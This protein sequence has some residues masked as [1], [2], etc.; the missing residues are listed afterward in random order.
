AQVAKRGATPQRV[1]D[2]EAL[3]K[4]AEAEEKR[5]GRA[6]IDDLRSDFDD[7]LG[8]FRTAGDLVARGPDGEDKAAI[9]AMKLDKPFPANDAARK[10]H[11]K[12]VAAM[13]EPYSAELA[14]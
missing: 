7:Q 9:T 8:E 11:V 3:I 6:S 1:K 2:F 10:E 4:Q 14:A 13:V 5:S 12:N